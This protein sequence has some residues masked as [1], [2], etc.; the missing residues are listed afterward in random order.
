MFNEFPYTN[1]EKIN[2]D[3]LLDLG[4]KLKADAESGAFDGERGPGIFG[5][6][7]IYAGGPVGGAQ[8]YCSKIG[9]AGV[10]DFIIGYGPAAGVNTLYLMKVTS[11]S[12][13]FLEGMTLLQITGPQGEPGPAGGV[14]EE[15]FDNLLET[16]NYIDMSSNPDMFMQG[17]W[18]YSSGMY[19][20]SNVYICT[21]SFLPNS[22]KK[23]TSDFSGISLLAYENGVY[24]GAYDFTRS[25]FRKAAYNAAFLTDLINLEVFRNEYPDYEFKISSRLA[26]GSAI[27]PETYGWRVHFYTAAVLKDDSRTQD[28]LVKLWVEHESLPI[29][30][31]W[32]NGWVNTNGAY[33]V[34]MFHRITGYLPTKGLS[35]YTAGRQTFIVYYDYDTSTSKYVFKGASA[36]IAL[37]STVKVNEVYGYCR[38]EYNSNYNWIKPIVAITANPSKLPAYWVDYIDSKIDSIKQLTEDNDEVFAFITDI[39]VPQNQM[40]SPD[41]VNYI[42]S[43]ISI[44]YVVNGGD[45]IN[46]NPS[47]REALNVMDRWIN[48]AYPSW[49]LLRGNHDTNYQG[50]GT[51]TEKDFTGHATKRLRNS[52][53]PMIENRNI[54]YFDN[55]QSKIRHIILDTITEQVV[56]ISDQVN[57]MKAKITELPIGWGVVV[58][59]HMYFAPSRVSAGVTELE[60]LNVGTQIKDGLDSIYDSA[61]ASII[62]YICGHCHRDYSIVTEKGYPIISTTCDAGGAQASNW[63]ID[64]PTRTVGTTNEQAFDIYGINKSTKTITTIR[65]GAGASGRNFSY[66]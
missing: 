31:E 35:I 43:K 50:S 44:P 63:D 38:V 41:I 30:V 2:L 29:D 24:V 40:H 39:H 22:I 14:S 34:D 11:V 65:I 62:A 32:G 37:N 46:S 58:I 47:R 16:I 52:I 12:G 3:W 15:D 51:V 23:V 13:D 25:T 64:N 45:Y 9:D 28:G 55:V 5:I 10:G 54:Y 61:N 42:N 66:N 59:T 33:S 7:S 1:Y 8:Y 20:N 57:W 17:A 60:A 36:E 49:Y 21:K 4:N 6:T 56:D 18:A 19:T 53:T 26:S 27:T 48:K